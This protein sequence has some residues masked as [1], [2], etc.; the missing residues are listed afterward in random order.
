MLP[1]GLRFAAARPRGSREKHSQLAEG[2]RRASRPSSFPG[3]GLGVTAAVGVRHARP[4]AQ[5]RGIWSENSECQAFR[6]KVL[7]RREEAARALIEGEISVGG[8]SRA[9]APQKTESFFGNPLCS[10]ENGSGAISARA[11]VGM[12]FY[13]CSI[14]VFSPEGSSLETFSRNEN[15]RER[16]AVSTSS[17]G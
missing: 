11:A 8:G 12:G 4:S 13:Q 9:G 17:G 10:H 1:D 16:N 15:L 2:R 7:R 5:K 14:A 3:S 6:S